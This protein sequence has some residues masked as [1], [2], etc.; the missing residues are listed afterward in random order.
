MTSRSTL[1]TGFSGNIGRP[2]V[3]LLQDQNQMPYLLAGRSKPADIAEGNFRYLDFTDQS[4]FVPALDNVQTIFLVRPPALANVQKYFTPFLQAAKLQGVEQIVFLSLQ[5]ADKI[6]VVPHRAIEQEIQK[7]NFKY[8][9]LR[10]S[11]FMQN[12]ST[13]HRDEIRLQNMIYVPAGKGLTSFIDCLDIA[14]VAAQVLQT[15]DQHINKIY[16]LTGSES[17]SYHVVAQI[18]TETLG[19]TIEYRNP[20]IISFITHQL[21]HRQPLSLALIMTGIYSAARFGQAGRTTDTVAKILNRPPIG[22]AEFAGR[23]AECWQS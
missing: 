1:I 12:L 18:L 6:K 13:M 4:S 19:R 10:P 2:L 20:D 8:T 7:L 16:E 22:F 11:F 17:L 3:Q 15:P 9:F 14:A 21:R 23:E 5:G